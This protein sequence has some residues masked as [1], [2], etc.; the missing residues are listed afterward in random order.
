MPYEEKSA[1]VMGMLAVVGFAVYL[2]VLLGMASTT[3]LA[4]VD[5]VP[6]LLWTIGGSIVVSIVIHIG[7]AMTSPTKGRSDLRDRQIYRFGESVGNGFL[8]AGAL[9]AML[10]AM[11]GIAPFWIANVIYLGFVLSA[12]LGSIA[13]IVAYRAGLPEW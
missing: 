10:F 13:K 6:A 7:I 1:W 2:I 11:F 5:Y 9:A 4:E 3:E 8:V 12:I